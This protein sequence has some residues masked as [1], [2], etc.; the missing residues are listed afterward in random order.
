MPQCQATLK[1]G[2]NKGSQCI[3][4]AKD[5]PFCGR[6][7]SSPSSPAQSVGATPLS[8]PIQKTPIDFGTAAQ[9]GFVFAEVCAGG[10][11]LSMGL[12]KAG[13][14]PILLNDID[15][16][17]C[18]TLTQTHP[19][20]TRVEC[21]SFLD[22]DWEPYVDKLDLLAGGVPCQEWSAAGTR[23]GGEGETGQLFQRFLEIIHIVRPKVFLIENVKGLT[24]H[25]NKEDGTRSIDNLI[26]FIQ[27]KGVY[28]VHWKVLNANHYGV[29]QAR[30]RVIFIGVLASFT[31]TYSYPEPLEG[32]PPV[33]GD[34]LYP[35]IDAPGS[36]YEPKRREIFELIP[37]GGDYRD[38]PDD[39]R[40]TVRQFNGVY[41]RL[42]PKKPSPTLLT[43]PSNGWGDKCHP[44][45][46]RPLNIKE[47]ARI[48]TF[49]D[50]Y[51]FYGSMT[52]IYRQIGNAVPIELAYHIGL[53]IAQF[54]AA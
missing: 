52:S 21:C 35:R 30:E 2:P 23:K 13:F 42:D 16:D 15:N 22:I 6:H 28:K 44:S 1:S 7:Q 18:R 11:G 31:K 39:I 19:E 4:K 32:E 36:Q 47:Y 14:H 17:C 9:Q 3:A 8:S 12:I 53:S 49:P 40:A 29:P 38:L 46:E 51:D 26:A 27:S 54:L 34:V 24:T 20:D 43:S 10:G 5:G 33:L 37:P 45:Q 41:G 25:K 48:Q 50:N